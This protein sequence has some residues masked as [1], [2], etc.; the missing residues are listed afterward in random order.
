MPDATEAPAPPHA[1]A[2]TLAELRSPAITA[3]WVAAILAVI[4]FVGFLFTGIPWAFLG[5]QQSAMHVTQS[6]GL[7]DV[8]QQGPVDYL[9]YAVLDFVR[10]LFFT[11]V[12]FAVGVLVSLWLLLPATPGT[13]FVPLVLRGLVASILGAA[14][15]TL[16]QLITTGPTVSIGNVSILAPQL[17]GFFAL[18]AS[19]APVVLLVLVV[20]A[21]VP[22]P[23]RT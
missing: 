19:Y 23:V 18:A 2:R 7:Y 20:R 6:G 21:Y 13:A 14:L 11:I 8:V 10:Q 12:P 5:A 22:R 9:G 15:A 3:A 16:V 1:P 4:A 17:L